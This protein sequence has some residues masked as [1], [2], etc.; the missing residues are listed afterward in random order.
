MYQDLLEVAESQ[1]AD[2]T[3]CDAFEIVGENRVAYSKNNEEIT[4]IDKTEDLRYGQ[5]E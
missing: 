2:V 3:V 1:D 4:V 5:S